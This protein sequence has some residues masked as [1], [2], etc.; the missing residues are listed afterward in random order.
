MARWKKPTKDEISENR[1]RL[2]ERAAAG[3]LRL[4]AA[5]L[6]IRKSLW[7]SQVTFARITGLT[8]RQVI[9]I[10]TG[11]ANPTVQTL[12]KVAGLFGFTVGFV[13]KSSKGMMTDGGS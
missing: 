11:K 1:K 9:E 2:R 10:E 3:D 6:E 12:E 4:P 13:P 8:K 7:L 5:V